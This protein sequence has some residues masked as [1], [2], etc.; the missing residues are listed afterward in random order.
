MPKDEWDS[1]ALNYTSGT[2]GLPKGVVSIFN[3]SPYLYGK[4]ALL[5]FNSLIFLLFKFF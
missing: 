1:I 3:N 5:T 4:S 2:T